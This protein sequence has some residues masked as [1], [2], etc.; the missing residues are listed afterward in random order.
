MVMASG[1]FEIEQNGDTL[2]VTPVTDLTELAYERIEVGAQE[3]LGLLDQV[4]IKNVVMDFHRTD[5]F[6][7]TALGFFVRLWKRARSRNGRMAFCN[8]SEHETEILKITGLDRLWTICS[9]RQEAMEAV[10]S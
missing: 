8:L 6:G 10:Q 9:S 1:V 7:S 2:V 3:L 4:H 5:Y